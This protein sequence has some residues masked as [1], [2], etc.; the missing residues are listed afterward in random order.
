MLPKWQLFAGVIFALATTALSAPLLLGQVGCTIIIN[1]PD[2][3]TTEVFVEGCP[4]N[5]CDPESGVMCQ[6]ASSARK[7]ECSDGI[8]TAGCV[9]KVVYN[10]DGETVA[11]ISCAR[12][13]CKSTCEKSA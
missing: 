6:L 1:R 3:T 13:N 8:D 12:K 2:A 10:P 5:N 4:S 7:C 11:S 9:G